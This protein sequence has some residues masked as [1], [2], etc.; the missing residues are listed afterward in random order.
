[1]HS[2]IKVTRYINVDDEEEL[3]ILFF[4][5]RFFVFRGLCIEC[6]GAGGVYSSNSW[7]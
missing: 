2:R 3:K 1:M 5:D 7:E 4:S 6:T